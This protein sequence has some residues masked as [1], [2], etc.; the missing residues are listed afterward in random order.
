MLMAVLTLTHS[1][2]TLPTTRFDLKTHLS[3][4]FPTTTSPL[5]LLRE[6]QEELEIA[7]PVK[8]NTRKVKETDM[9]Q[10]R[11]MFSHTKRNSCSLIVM[12]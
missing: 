12:C 10:D 1:T 11:S 7:K 9:R 6:E 8:R 4:R 3:V 5:H 2:T